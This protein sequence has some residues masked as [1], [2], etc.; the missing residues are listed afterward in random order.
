MNKLNTTS[1]IFS[2]FAKRQKLL[3]TLVNEKEN[4]RCIDHD[5]IYEELSG[6]DR[7]IISLCIKIKESRLWIKNNRKK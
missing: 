1:L 7:E 4:G 2:L 5:V 6:I 3:D